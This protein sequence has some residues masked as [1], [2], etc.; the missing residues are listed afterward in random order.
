MLIFTL[1]LQSFLF[2]G[3]TAIQASEARPVVGLP[4]GG[5]APSFKV[6][7]QSGQERS[8]KDIAGENGTI[9]LFFRSADW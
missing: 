3:K 8:L 5:I 7:D 6:N 1:L 9:L 4:V 2:L